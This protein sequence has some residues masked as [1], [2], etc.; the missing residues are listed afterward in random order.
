MTRTLQ[1]LPPRVFA[2]LDKIS[3]EVKVVPLSELELARKGEASKTPEK[4][5][6][7][8]EKEIQNTDIPFPAPIPRKIPKK[9]G[10][11]ELGTVKRRA[12]DSRP[13]KLIYLDSET[14]L[15]VGDKDKFEKWVETVRL[16]F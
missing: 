14:G 11:E 12:H 7:E 1:T 6:R 10:Y 8:M 5:F 9:R 13:A 16:P 3:P 2:A 4:T 15:L